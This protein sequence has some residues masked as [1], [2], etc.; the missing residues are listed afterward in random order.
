L[1]SFC[2]S[3]LILDLI[4]DHPFVWQQTVQSSI[5]ISFFVCYSTSPSA[6]QRAV[7][8]ECFTDSVWF[9]VFCMFT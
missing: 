5:P 6:L 3:L 8:V 4:L 2:I 7:L 9:F 1:F